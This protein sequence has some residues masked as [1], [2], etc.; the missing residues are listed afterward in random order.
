MKFLFI[1]SFV[2][3]ECLK[4]FSDSFRQL[5]SFCI[6]ALRSQNSAFVAAV[7]TRSSF[8]SLQ[9]SMYRILNLFRALSYFVYFFFSFPLLRFRWK[10]LKFMCVSHFSLLQNVCGERLPRQVN[11]NV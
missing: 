5:L 9:R 1:E 2:V 6:H 4:N 3:W 8:V 10:S 11:R 7:I